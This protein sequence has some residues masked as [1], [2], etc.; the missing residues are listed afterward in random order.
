MSP[1]VFYNSW[2]QG[3]QVT[4]TRT[5][6][7]CKKALLDTPD[8]VEVVDT[9]SDNANQ[10]STPQNTREPSATYGKPNLTASDE[11]PSVSPIA[12]NQPVAHNAIVSEFDQHELDIALTGFSQC[13]VNNSADNHKRL[14]VSTVT[15]MSTAAVNVEMSNAPEDSTQV[16]NSPQTPNAVNQRAN[17]KSKSHNNENSLRNSDIPCPS[18][19]GV[20]RESPI[21]NSSPQTT[22]LSLA[23]FTIK[24]VRQPS[25][26]T[27]SRSSVP[28]SVLASESDDEERRIKSPIDMDLTR[29]DEPIV[30]EA[31]KTTPRCLNSNSNTETQLSN[32]TESAPT[33][34][35]AQE[36]MESSFSMETCS[37]QVSSELKL[38]KRQRKKNSSPKKKG[39]RTTKVREMG[40][41]LSNTVIN[42]VCQPHE[43]SPQS[44]STITHQLNNPELINN[45]VE[46]QGNASKLENCDANSSKRIL[47]LNGIEMHQSACR[48][49]DQS[50]RSTCNELR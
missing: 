9:T 14:P 33:T 3:H 50:Q 23:N 41:E 49:L 30:P 37:D 39:K 17:E 31:L 34:Q 32:L 7:L 19:S 48:D 24:P 40:E 38:K 28:S 12:P 27:S 22:A 18:N 4:S 6:A 13:E 5:L 44:N 26:D 29:I 10:T 47:R 46:S 42:K 35:S 43:L 20:S 36:L 21:R 16:N 25:N 11:N 2:I 15:S 8:D 45:C 1:K